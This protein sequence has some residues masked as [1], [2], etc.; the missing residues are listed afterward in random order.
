MPEARRGLV[1]FTR[2][3]LVFPLSPEE[4]SMA[5]WCFNTCCELGCLHPGARLERTL[6][7]RAAFSPEGALEFS[8]GFTLGNH[9][10]HGQG[11]KGRQKA[12]LAC[13]AALS[14]LN[15]GKGSFRR[16]NPGLRSLGP[17]SRK[18]VSGPTRAGRLDLSQ[19]F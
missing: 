16:V 12:S 9:S 6:A 2:A 3:F 17:S 15:H 7:N 10:L 19:V 4:L 14:G 18:T 1:G 13:S 5:A 8:P 11:L